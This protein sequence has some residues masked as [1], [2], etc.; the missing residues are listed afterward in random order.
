MKFRT[1]L[2]IWALAL[3]LC[4]PTA[5]YFPIS[6]SRDRTRRTGSSLAPSTIRKGRSRTNLKQSVPTQKSGAG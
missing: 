2:A 5:E 4:M 1:P 6:K 3:V